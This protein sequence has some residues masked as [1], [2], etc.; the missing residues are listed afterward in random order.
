MD[1]MIQEDIEHKSAVLIMKGTKITARLFPSGREEK[2]R[3]FPLMR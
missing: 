3:F 2:G 1:Y